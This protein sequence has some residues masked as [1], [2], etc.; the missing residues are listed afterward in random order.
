MKNLSSYPGRWNAVMRSA[1]FWQNFVQI[2]GDAHGVT[3][4]SFTMMPPF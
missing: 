4:A 3:S 2:N 1:T